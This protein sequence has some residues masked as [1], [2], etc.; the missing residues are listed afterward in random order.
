MMSATRRRLP[1][2]VRGTRRRDGCTETAME[3]CRVGDISLAA[4]RQQSVQPEDI[5]VAFGHG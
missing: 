2:P 4:G 5:G 1:L 3:S